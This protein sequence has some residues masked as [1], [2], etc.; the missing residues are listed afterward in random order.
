L[1]YRAKS[2]C[3]KFCLAEFGSKTKYGKV[4]PMSEKSAEGMPV[5]MTGSRGQI[6]S[7][8]VRLLGPEY[9]ITT[10]DIED[11]QDATD[12]DRLEAAAQGQEAVIHL[13]WDSLHENAARPKSVYPPNRQAA[14][15]ALQLG[16]RV[17]SVRRIIMPSSVHINDYSAASLRRRGLTQLGP[18][19][20]IEPDSAY[21]FTKAAI[22]DKARRVAVAAADIGKSLLLFV[23]RF[24]DLNPENIPNIRRLEEDGKP[25]VWLSHADCV[26]F[27]K[28]CLE[29]SNIPRPA[30]I[31]PEI[32]P[33]NYTH[34]NVLSRNEGGVHDLENTIGW[35]PL[36]GA[37]F[38]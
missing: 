38:T 23:A 16:L 12:L 13:A 11:G 26:R 29:V 18:F 30:G 28:R 21:G 32:I 35:T 24:G 25:T 1:L 31:G 27:I 10:F 22:E 3:E 7:V 5:L 2:L 19:T 34:L 9:H 36:D 14:F 33:D 8:L 6:G 17:P 4:I 20:P 37:R 15:N